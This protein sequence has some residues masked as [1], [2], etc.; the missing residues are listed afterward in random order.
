MSAVT[1]LCG[2]LQRIQIAPSGD[3]LAKRLEQVIGY[4]LAVDEFG[5]LDKEI[6]NTI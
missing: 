5:L 1:Q 3:D 2:L 4:L 6:G